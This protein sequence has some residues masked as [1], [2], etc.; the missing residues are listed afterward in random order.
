MK[1]KILFTLLMSILIA[2]Q[3][4]WSKSKNAKQEYYQLTMYRYNTATQEKMLDNYFQSALIPAL[5][6]MGIPSV[7]VFK[8]IANDTSANKT[9]YVLVPVKSLNMIEEINGKL[10]NNEKYL[11]AAKDYLYAPYNSPAYARM[12]KIILKAFHMAPV[13]Q[14]PKLTSPKNE[15][16]YEL[17]SY[18]SATENLFRKKVHMFNEGGEMAIFAKLNFNAVFYSEVIS[19]SQMPN[20]MYMTTFENMADREAHWAA[21]RDHPDWKELS[22]RPEY[23]NTVSRSVI[24]FLRP[25]D[26]SD[27]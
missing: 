7:G 26:Y 16:V 3:V 23:S 5:H 9:L 4:L 24:T 27:F 15:R 19:G 1:T 10:L 21:F 8:A 2:P 11:S 22:P 18:E 20:L 14:K 17:R 6:D 25:A 12:E 13:M